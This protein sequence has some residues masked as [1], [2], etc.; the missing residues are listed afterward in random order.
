MLFIVRF[1]GNI[2][3]YADWMAASQ[4]LKRPAKCYDRGTFT[5][6]VHCRFPVASRWL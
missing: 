2:A 3:D 5:A 4:L 6:R 1:E